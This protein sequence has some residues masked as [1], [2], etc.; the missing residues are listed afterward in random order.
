MAK[1]TQVIPDELNK[2]LEELKVRFG[3]S[4]SSIINAA[5]EEYL[6]T[7]DNET[8]EKRIKALEKEVFKK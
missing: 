4:K 7:R 1:I 6:R 3:M 2:R 5:I 8:L